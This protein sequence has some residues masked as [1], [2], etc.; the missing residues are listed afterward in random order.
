MDVLTR[1]G[2]PR[3]T[4]LLLAGVANLYCRAEHRHTD[5]HSAAITAV[6]DRHPCHAQ[7]V[8]RDC[9]EHKRERIRKDLGT[10]GRLRRS[11]SHPGLPE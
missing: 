9:D 3:L 5:M 10:A 7:D 4:D 2:K 1:T 8:D 6:R 11:A